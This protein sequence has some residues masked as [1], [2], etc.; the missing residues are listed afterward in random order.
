MNAYLTQFNRAE[1]ARN[2]IR[3]KQRSV[4][5]E[6][7]F[8]TVVRGGRAGP[9]RL[10]EAEAKKKELEERQKKKGAKD[11]FYRFQTREKR[12]EREGELRRQF[13]EDKRRVEEMRQRRGKLVVSIYDQ[14]FGALLTIFVLASIIKIELFSASKETQRLS[15]SIDTLQNS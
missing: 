6:D 11:D 9:A 10:E 4:P 3:S 8:V 1:L 14:Q 13:D 2:R 7:G 15:W 12:K 5:D